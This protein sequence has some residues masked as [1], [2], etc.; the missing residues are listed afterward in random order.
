MPPEI[1]AAGRAWCPFD[2]GWYGSESASLTIR[3][4][5]CYEMLTAG[6]GPFRQTLRLI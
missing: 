6:F 5:F 3:H 1:L 4:A 2:I